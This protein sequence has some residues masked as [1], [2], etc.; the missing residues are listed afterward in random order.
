MREIPCQEKV[1]DDSAG[2]VSYRIYGSTGPHILLLDGLLGGAELW[3]PLVGHFGDRYQFLHGAGFGSEDDDTQIASPAGH[4]RNALRIL[5]AEGVSTAAVLASAMGTLIALELVRLAPERVAL[6]SLIGGGAHLR[7]GQTSE[8]RLQASLFRF[9]VRRLSKLPEPLLQQGLSLLRG[10]EA[11]LWARRLRLLGSKADPELFA[12]LLRKI[13]K[14]K[15]SSMV[16]T[17]A[18][19]QIHDAS[20]VLPRVGVPVLVVAAGQDPLTSRGAME[21]LVSEIPDAQYLL[22]SDAGHFAL[23]DHADLLNLRLEK[24]LVEQDYR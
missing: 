9:V 11:Y 14:R 20:D 15:V 1:L 18:L 5:D 6:L 16:G 3:Q 23:L 22:L 2:R 13:A 4:A 10:P 19:A 24:F 17:L 7:A 8:S 12:R 21:Q